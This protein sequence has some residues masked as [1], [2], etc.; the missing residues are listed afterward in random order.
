MCSN[1]VEQFKYAI[2]LKK[3][4]LKVIPFFDSEEFY[5]KIGNFLDKN[6]IIIVDDKV[7]NFSLIFEDYKKILNF[8]VISDK[9]YD[10][11]ILNLNEKNSFEFLFEQ[12]KTYL[13]TN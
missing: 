9:K 6:S 5:L 10:D 8:I 11:A 13:K 1:S 4:N 7:G 3:E 12:I 2:A